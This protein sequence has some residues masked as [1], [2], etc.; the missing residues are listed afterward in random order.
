MR[1]GLLVLLLAGITAAAW[2]AVGSQAGTKHTSSGSVVTIANVAGMS[3]TC[4]F[5]PFNSTVQFL[6]FGPI[7]EELAFVNELKSGAATPWLASKYTWSKNAKKLTFTIRQGVKWS[8]GKPLTAADVLFTFQLLKKHKALDLQAVWAVLKSVSRKGSNQVVLTF[9][10]AAAPYFYYV[11]GQT[12]IVPKHIWAKISNPVKYTDKNPVGSGPYTVGNCNPQR[13]IYSKNTHYWQKGKPKIDTVVYPAY[14]DNPPANLDLST[15]Q[16][17][18]GGQYIS[19]IKTAYTGKSKDNH[20]WFPPVANVSIFINLKNPILKNVA[21]RRAMAYA[22]NRPHVA[23]L[24]ESGYEPPGNQT[25]IVSP[26][27]KSWENKKLAKQITYD[28]KKAKQI[29]TKAGFKQKNGVFQ[30]KSGKPLSFTMINI[31]GYDDWI[32]SASIVQDEL[33]AIGI[34]VTT[35]NIS[36]NAYDDDTFNGHFQLAYDGNEAGGPSPY[37]EMRQELYSKN[38]APIG[39]Q[40]SSNWERYYNKKV[41]KEIESYAKTTSLSKQHS[42][43]SQLEAAMVRDVPIIPITEGVDFYEYNTKSI[44]GWVTPKNPYAKPSPYEVPDWGVVLTHLR[45]KG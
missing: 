29:L 6:A 42:I 8:D 23:K 15:G 27:F 44:T 26:T 2:T 20:Y 12:P 11:A 33:K 32:A 17:Q 21:V 30:T 45:P 41:D 19:N 25:G 10:S 1:R 13:I 22:I 43:V 34:K 18:W 7:Y 5:N 24:G 9:K 40:A 39:K 38:S 14:T 36:S 16:D 31:S 28:P 3:W 4:N 35:S 37:Y